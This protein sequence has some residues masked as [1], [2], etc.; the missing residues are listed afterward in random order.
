MGLQDADRMGFDDYTR[1]ENTHKIPYLPTQPHTLPAYA[2]RH[3]NFLCMYQYCFWGVFGRGF[4][5][6][7]MAAFLCDSGFGCSLDF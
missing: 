1:P 4:I 3:V 6:M 2:N 7:S 5:S